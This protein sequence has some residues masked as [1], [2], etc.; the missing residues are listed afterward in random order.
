M[1]SISLLIL[2]FI[3]ASCILRAQEID[4]NVT[5]N[6][7]SLT[8]EAR[9]NLSDFV[10]QIEQYINS[11]HWTRDGIDGE[12]IKCS[13]DISFQGSPREKHYVVQAF[14][15]SQRPIYKTD[16]STAMLRILDDKW[17]FDY[18]RNQSLMHNDTQ[19]DPLLS[20]ID[21]YINVIIGYDFDSY[22]YGDGTPYLQR[23]MEIVTRSRGGKGWELSTPTGYSRGQIMDELLNPKFRNFREAVYK[24]HYKGL[25]LLHKDE[26][27]ARKAMLSSLENIG[28]LQAKINQRSQAVKVFFDTKYLEIADIF[29]RDP[30]EGVLDRLAEVDPGHRQTYQEYKKKSN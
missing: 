10:D 16:R 15:G 17:E 5:V 18:L 11:Y 30:D 14:I 4:C 25:D 12:K 28:K 20:F 26:V 2:L 29:S 19:F 23:A 21:Y 3:V 13:I 1:K 6:L 7:E 24:Y 22:R 27:K 9:E 8:A